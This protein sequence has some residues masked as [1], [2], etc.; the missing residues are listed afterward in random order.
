M[1]P[2]EIKKL[3]DE[4]DQALALQKDHVPA[5]PAAEAP[6]TPESE[7]GPGFKESEVLGSSEPLRVAPVSAQPIPHPQAQAQP[8][9]GSRGEGVARAFLATLPGLTATI[10]AQLAHK[11][12]YG[13]PTGALLEASSNGLKAQEQA[14][15][16][17][18]REDAAALAR[19]RQA[20]IDASAKELHDLRVGKLKRDAARDTEGAD[21]NSKKSQAAR[22]AI[23]QAYPDI[24]KH[25]PHFE[26]MSLDEL[27]S[28]QPAVDKAKSDSAAERQAQLIG[29]RGETTIKVEGARQEGRKEIE[30]LKQEG[31]L[32]LEK[33]KQKGRVQLK[34]GSGG[35]S[36][37]PYDPGETL[38]AL[39]AAYGG[40]TPP[41]VAQQVKLAAALRDPAKREAA[42]QRILANAPKENRQDQRAK[43]QE[44]I[45]FNKANEGP[46]NV[47]EDIERTRQMLRKN[48][49]DMDNYRGED[50]PGEGR[51]K[52][53]L[54]SWML[55]NEG[56]AMR[57]QLQGNMSTYLRDLSGKQASDKERQQI[58][59][60]VGISKGASVSTL[61][62]GLHRLEGIAKA[63]KARAAAGY[64][65]AHREY[66]GARPNMAPAA[67]GNA[68]DPEQGAPA[69]PS[70][71]RVRD[72]K[73]GKTG[74]FHG[75]ADE[76]KA[77]GYEVL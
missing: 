57:A 30:G 34:R 77:K 68:P 47:L 56:Q 61:I 69:A 35:G 3:T 42:L 7:L 54:P 1:T 20:G 18:D 4:Q 11:A 49:V 41:E 15:A 71:V 50:V 58:Q 24:A 31:A 72:P 64:T 60:I 67:P 27:S 10:G 40:K 39:D 19:R 13:R 62:Q 6:W 22:A 8:N 51:V 33:T 21:P 53:L 52:S 38:Q 37:K 36:S 9:E 44:A 2:E 14:Q 16:R 26:G 17:L 25:L 75:T 12:K 5:P 70:G 76:A 66:E 32:N 63:Q 74:T 73:S 65:S 45:A 59:E 29:A 55:S 43:T 23:A 28:I 46:E 48:G